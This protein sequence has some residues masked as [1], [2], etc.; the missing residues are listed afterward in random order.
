MVKV[1]NPLLR[2][3]LLR[4]PSGAQGFGAGN[5]LVGDVTGGD[6]DMPSSRT[7]ME[8]T[9]SWEFD[10][11]GVEEHESTGEGSANINWHEGHGQGTGFSAACHCCQGSC[12]A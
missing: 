6:P 7:V 11:H 4:G 9:G 8:G 5:H 3:Y 12:D 1:G 2:E 10:G